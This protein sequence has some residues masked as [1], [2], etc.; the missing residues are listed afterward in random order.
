[1]FRLG[2]SDNALGQANALAILMFI[3]NM[4]LVAVLLQLFRKG[5]RI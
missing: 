3:V 2:F 4:I 5:G 1:M